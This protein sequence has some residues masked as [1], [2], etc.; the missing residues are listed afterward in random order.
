MHIPYLYNLAGT[1][2]KAQKRLRMLM[3]TWFRND[4][5]GVPGDEDGGGLSAFYVFSAMGFYPIAPGI[6]EYQIGSPLFKKIRIKLQNGR[7][8]NVIAENNSQANKYVQSAWLNG[9]E[10]GKTSFTHS[11]ITEG[12]TLILKMGD[13]P[14][15]RWG[16]E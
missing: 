8:F 11:D 7:T 4:L 9:K 16:V 12:G 15:Y 2:W 13:K 10:L 6:P 3:D 5:M 14:D 1:P